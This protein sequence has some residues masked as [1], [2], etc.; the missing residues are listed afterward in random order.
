MSELE[1][2]PEGARPADAP[3]PAAD[4]SDARPQKRSPEERARHRARDAAFNRRLRTSI[5]VLI[6]NALAPLVA[7]IEELERR[8]GIVH[9]EE[10]T[11]TN[12]AP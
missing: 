12:D 3:P 10:G 8:A 6:D 9:E 2:G 11:P 1:S 5:D 4:A 7:R